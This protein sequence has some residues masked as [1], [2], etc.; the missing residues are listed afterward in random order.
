MLRM[1]Q[2]EYIRELYENEGMSLREIARQTKKDF[3]TVQ[4]YAYQN[5]WNPP[6]KLKTEPEAFPVM[7]E[8]IRIV[9]EWLEA[10][11]REPRKQRHTVKRI[12]VRLREEHG[13]KGS[14]GSVKRYVAIKKTQMK[15]YRESF[16]PLSHPPGYAQVDFGKFKYY[17]T[18]G[19][20]HEGY[21][22]IVSFPQANTG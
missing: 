11:E 3:R 9:N 12:F 5:D 21:A 17:D 8:Y 13:Y 14:Y 16:L 22:L 2:V 1:P 4:K 15:K 10:D 7:G 6:V 19:R 18:L 20:A